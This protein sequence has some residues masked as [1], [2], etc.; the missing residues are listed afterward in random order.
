MNWNAS[1]KLLVAKIVFGFGTVWTLLL[2]SGIVNAQ[3]PKVDVSGHWQDSN[4]QYKYKLTQN[5]D[6]VTSEGSF[7]PAHGHFT[8]PNTFVLSWASATFTGTVG[9][10]N[11][12]EI[13]WNNNSIWLFVTK[14][15][16]LV[17]H[18]ATAS[19]DVPAGQADGSSNPKCPPAKCGVVVVRGIQPET[20]NSGYACCDIKVWGQAI[21]E[22]G[23]QYECA[24][25]PRNVEDNQ[26]QW[27]DCGPNYS[28]FDGPYV[29]EFD[30][31]TG[32]KTGLVKVQFRNWRSRGQRA[33]VQVTYSTQEP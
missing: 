33:T 9:G 31:S 17:P 29:F 22:G 18:T 10:N 19:L 26:V 24:K 8:G 32:G 14:G 21:F 1:F 30:R 3:Q 25:V 20:P 23:P 15:P 11:G 6:T 13:F 4:G 27:W 7:G 5:G 28:R 16:V 2:L 12:N